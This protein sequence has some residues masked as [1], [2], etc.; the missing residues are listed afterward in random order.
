MGM[1]F[2]E[3]KEFSPQNPD[4]HPVIFGQDAGSQT[5]A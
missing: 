1:I 3:T 4:G 5:D 2:C